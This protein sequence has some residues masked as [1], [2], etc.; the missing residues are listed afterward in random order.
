M[1]DQNITRQILD[2]QERYH[3]YSTN[4][5]N[6]NQSKFEILV[7]LKLLEI[8]LRD[9]ENINLEEIEQNIYEMNSL[10]DQLSEIDEYID[11][12]KLMVELVTQELNNL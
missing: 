10:Y 1:Q 2:I 11:G 5:L 9:E 8:L 3:Y 4:L 6:A 12:I 7:D